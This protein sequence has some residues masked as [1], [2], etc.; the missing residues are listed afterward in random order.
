MRTLIIGLGNI[1]L[2]DDGVGIYIVDKLQKMV[3][4]KNV[5]FAICDTDILRLMNKY[6][7]Q[8]RVIIIDAI[9]T[10]LPAGSIICLKE[11]GLFSHKDISR[12][13]HQISVIE[14]LELMKSTLPEFNKCEI[15]FVG[16]QIGDTRLNQELT[17]SVKES[18]EKIIL[19]M[20]FITFTAGSIIH[21]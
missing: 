10:K 16:L 19:T 14:G 6:D 15:Y 18:A 21:D 3:S 20:K 11:D 4:D 2:Q 8:G 1:L 9:N 17:P 13:A 12:S 5:D 7:N